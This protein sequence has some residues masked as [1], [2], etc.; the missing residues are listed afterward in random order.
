MEPSALSCA[1]RY[2]IGGHRDGIKD[3][4]VRKA[5][6]VQPQYVRLLL[7]IAVM[8]GFDTWTADV[9]QAYLKSAEPCVTRVVHLQA[10]ARV[11]A[12]TRA[13]PET[14]QAALWLL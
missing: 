10:R 4:M 5:A 8:L 2:V 6:T 14:S 11:R 3:M 9:R 13:G 1:K 12:E 7:A